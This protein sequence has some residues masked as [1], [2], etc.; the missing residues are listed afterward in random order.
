MCEER[1]KTLDKKTNSREMEEDK[2]RGKGEEGRLR[3][4]GKV[5]VGGGE[6]LQELQKEI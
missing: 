6:N 2:G 4:D 1:E 3:I 5:G